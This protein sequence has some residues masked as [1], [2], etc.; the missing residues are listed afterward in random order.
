MKPHPWGCCIKRFA[1]NNSGISLLNQTKYGSEILLEDELVL[2]SFCSS[3]LLGPK[4]CFTP[5]WLLWLNSMPVREASKDLWLKICTWPVLSSESSFLLTLFAG[6]QKEAV[7]GSTSLG[8]QNVATQ[9]GRVTSP[10]IA[11]AYGIL[12][13][14]LAR[15]L[16]VWSK[17]KLT[18]R[19]HTNISRFVFSFSL[20]PSILSFCAFTFNK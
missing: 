15:P 13:C 3:F 11:P 16:V 2:M 6:G 9:V 7:I 1:W 10:P 18:P 4:Q 14:L 20:Y 17:T 12:S 5:Q 19:L 8:A